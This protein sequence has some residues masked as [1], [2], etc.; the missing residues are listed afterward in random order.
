MIIV[1]Y[2]LSF[3]VVLLSFLWAYSILKSH[4]NKVLIVFPV[5]LIILALWVIITKKV[6]I[7]GILG[8]FGFYPSY[9][10]W[11][12]KKKSKNEE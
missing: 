2:L 4:L 11:K 7:L 10:N 9:L 8:I 1:T 12:R 6:G 5:L 3:L